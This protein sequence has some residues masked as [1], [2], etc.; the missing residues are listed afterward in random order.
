MYNLKKSIGQKSIRLKKTVDISKVK[1]K[2]NSGRSSSAE[3][4]DIKKV[5]KKLRVNI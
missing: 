2:N 1:Q 5:T 3:V 4:I